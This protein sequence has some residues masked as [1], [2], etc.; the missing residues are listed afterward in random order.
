MSVVSLMIPFVAVHT[1][2]YT[3]IKPMDNSALAFSRRMTRRCRP[4]GLCPV[5]LWLELD[6]QQGVY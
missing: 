1:A 2:L 6:L 4:D 5:E 3:N